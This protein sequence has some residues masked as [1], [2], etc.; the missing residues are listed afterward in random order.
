MFSF[1]LGRPCL[2]LVGEAFNFGMDEF[3]ELSLRELI[4]DSYLP[5]LVGEPGLLKTLLRVSTVDSEC[6]S[7]FELIDPIWSF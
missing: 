1:V 6:G 3:I 5:V 4:C 7:F 2:I